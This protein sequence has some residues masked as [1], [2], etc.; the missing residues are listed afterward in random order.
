MDKYAAENLVFFDFESRSKVPITLGSYR[1]AVEADAILLA[2]AIGNG[3]VQLVERESRALTWADM[4]DDLKAAYAAGKVF[5]AW[6][7]GFDRCIWNYALR[8]SPFLAPAQVIDAR[9]TALAHNLPDDLETASTRLGGPGKQKDGKALIAKFCGIDAI[10]ASDDPEAYARFC[11]YAKIDV[12]ELRRV[13]GLMVPALTDYDWQTYQANEVVNDNGAGVDI[14]FCKEAARLAAEEGLRIG[15]RLAVLTGGVITSINQNLRLAQWIH[16]RLPST[17]AR[18]VR[19]KLRR[20]L[21]I[22]AARESSQL[23]VMV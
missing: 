4:P 8:D 11:S 6:N 12:V 7:T 2:Y 9:S 17:E 3:P 19:T 21:A 13:F 23:I 20:E 14:A 22:L 18:L 1:Y 16:D 15:L 5:C 10:A